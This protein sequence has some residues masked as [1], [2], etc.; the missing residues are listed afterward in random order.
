MWRRLARRTF[1]AGRPAV[2]PEQ[3]PLVLVTALA[4]VG[5][6]AIVVR[7]LTG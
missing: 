4:I 7:V 3:W 2:F 1:A 5:G 6:I